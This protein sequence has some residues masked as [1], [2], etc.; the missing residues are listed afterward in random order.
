MTIERHATANGAHLEIRK[1]DITA[2]VIGA[3]FNCHPDKT[4]LR[5]YTEKR[6]V[7]FED[8]DNAAMRRGRWLEPSFPRALEDIRP[9]W[10]VEPA[11]VYLRDP[12][13]KLGATPDFFITGD[14]RGLGVLQAKTV[15]PDA[16]RKH[17]DNGREIP[18]WIILQN[19]TECLL[20]EQAFGQ[21]TFGVIAAMTGFDYNISCELFDIA[22]NPST[23]SEIVTR[24]WRFWNDVETGHEPEP[25]FDKD[26]ETIQAL[27]PRE[28]SGSARDLS[29]NNEIPVLL[30]RRAALCDAIKRHEAD[31]EAIET[32]LKFLMAEAEAVTGVPGWRITYKTEHRKEYIVPAKSRRVLRIY[33][34][35]EK[36]A[37]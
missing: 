36:E 17:W 27:F 2:S 3:L 15:G 18:I 28:I 20:A 9:Q 12:E 14:S 23:R 33:D 8:K 16:F 10:Q 29:G 19:V 22:P 31:C 26:R 7:S 1:R 24:V 25:D 30:A 34:R 21:P 35:R 11:K 6:G 13:L 32:E 37:L 5:L 4:A